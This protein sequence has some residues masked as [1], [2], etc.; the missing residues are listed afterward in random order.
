M[1]RLYN[2]VAQEY[3]DFTKSK[4]CS[5]LLEDKEFSSRLEDIYKPVEDCH[6]ICMEAGE[7]KRSLVKPYAELSGALSEYYGKLRTHMN[8]KLKEL[9]SSEESHQKRCYI[10]LCWIVQ[11]V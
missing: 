9:T 3:A 2:E 6:A 5:I 7:E 11:R 4:L 8:A 1:L 10:Y